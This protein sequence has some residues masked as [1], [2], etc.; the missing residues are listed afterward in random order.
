M[1]DVEVGGPGIAEA[2][3]RG[4]P[5]KDDDRILK[6]C[7]GEAEGGS[8]R[9]GV[10]CGRTLGLSLIRPALPGIGPYTYFPVEVW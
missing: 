6:W 2:G 3:P 8:M 9:T 5:G 1:H 10:N 4:I 7:P